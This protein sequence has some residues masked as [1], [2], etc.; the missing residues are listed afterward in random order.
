MDQEQ[1]WLYCYTTFCAC[2]DLSLL[3]L[4]N[5]L[6]WFTFLVKARVFVFDIP[7]FFQ[8]GCCS[9]R[10]RTIALKTSAFNREF[11]DFVHFMNVQFPGEKKSGLDCWF[12]GH[13]LQTGQV[14]KNDFHPQMV[15]TPD[16]WDCYR[17]LGI[18]MHQTGMKEDAFEYSPPPFDR[19]LWTRRINETVSVMNYPEGEDVYERVKEMILSRF[20]QAI[21]E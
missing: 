9:G 14:T 8:C 20:P 11:G 4:F 19:G 10:S 2:R 6:N 15:Q 13:L 3:S 7:Y 1:K 12:L 17:N 18:D 21:L 5:P 16:E